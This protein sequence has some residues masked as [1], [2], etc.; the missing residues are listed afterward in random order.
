MFAS[1]TVF[2]LGAGASWHYG[3]PTGEQLVQGVAERAAL[4]G[5][6]ALAALN[7]PYTNPISA[8]PSFIADQYWT[9]RDSGYAGMRDAWKAAADTCS[10]MTT[11]L[12]TVDSLVIDYF[13]GQ[14][15]ELRELG[16]LLIA[17]TILEAEADSL[18]E[19]ANI[20]R[21]SALE[22]LAKGSDQQVD[23]SKF[24]DRWY[25]FILHNIVS[26]CETS[27]D[28]LKND[29]WFVTFNYDVSLDYHIY[30]G[31]KA[32]SLFRSDHIE[33]FLADG[34]ITHVYGQVRSDGKQ[35][36]PPIEFGTL[37]EL[38]R[39]QQDVA[40]F[41][42]L[43]QQQTATV[44]EC[45]KSIRTVAPLE[46]I[47]NERE[48]DFARRLID[49]ARYVYI[50]GYGFD[51]QNSRIL[52]LQE[53]LRA[54]RKRIMFTNLGNVNRIN[55]KASV[56]LTGSSTAFVERAIHEQASR[57]WFAEKSVRD[58]YEAMQLDF[59]SLHE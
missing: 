22:D 19:G 30:Q 53:A 9:R 52:G 18:A 34:R 31:L 36:P 15:P 55:K 54:D 33:R 50:L 16:K 2:I 23:L 37:R 12:T 6:Y 5:R 21:R 17:W 1:K 48:V 28:L 26:D 11:K 38:H 46:K 32:I 58:V 25:R 40:A 24:K 59:Y 27:E 43:W 20:N 7:S 10:L 47:G 57:G 39:L 29:V 56:L 41:G 51:E 13:L 42:N 44:Y 8:M 3:Y 4:L 35:A 49:E 14:N 45:S